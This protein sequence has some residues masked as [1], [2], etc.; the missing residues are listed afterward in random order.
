M[1][2]FDKISKKY[3]F[4]A[5]SVNNFTDNHHSAMLNTH[6]TTELN[7]KPNFQVMLEVP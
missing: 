2:I 6:V 4:M 5:I 1:N 3:P 7:S